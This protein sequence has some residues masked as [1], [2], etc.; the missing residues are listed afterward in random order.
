M[1]SIVKG[2]FKVGNWLVNPAENTLSNSLQTINIEPKAMA[3][4]CML[5]EAKGGVVSREDIM[6]K[7]WNERYVTDYALNNLISSLRKYLSAESSPESYIKT[8]PKKGYQIVANIVSLEEPKPALQTEH[9]SEYE[10]STPIPATPQD[11]RLTTKPHKRKYVVLAGLLLVI[12]TLGFM[13]THKQEPAQPPPTSIAVLPFEVFDKEAQLAFF[14]DGLAD[15]I[16]H[17]LNTVDGFSVISRRSSFAYKD[18]NMNAKD[19]A[20]ELGVTY[21]LEGSVREEKNAMR[22]TVQLVNAI[23]GTIGWSRVFT[24]SQENGF[25]IQ[26]EISTDIAQSMD[27]SFTEFEKSKLRYQPESSE[28]FLHVLRG[29]RLN[30]IGNIEAVVKAKD[31]FLMATLLDP[32]YD[33]A[34]VDLGVSYLLLQQQKA[35]KPQEASELFQEAINNALAINP[36][37]PEAHAAYGI[38]YYNKGKFDLSKASFEKALSQKPKLYLALVNYANLLRAN[39][40]PEKARELYLRAKK[41]APLSS[42]IQWGIGQTNQSLGKLDKA[43]QSYETCINTSPGNTNCLLGLAYSYRLNMQGSKADK[44]LKTIQ[45][46]VSPTDYYYKL[47]FAWHALQT[48][49]LETVVSIVEPLTD[50][51]GFG[52]P[53]QTITYAKIGLDQAESWLKRLA[54]ADDSQK[55]GLGYKANYA[56]AAYFSGNCEVAIMYYENML[57]HQANLASDADILA[58]G[59]TYISNLAYCYREQSLF[60]KADTKVAQ[61]GEIIS[62]LPSAQKSHPGFAFVK[63]QY[64]LLNGNTTQAQQEIELI[65]NSDWGLK[66]LLEKDPIVTRYRN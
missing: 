4:L 24:A 19:I 55:T 16:I 30:Q 64:A 63:A 7:I 46:L 18:T 15:E 40:Q 59:V 47:A 25:A 44:T 8:R 49:D 28:A 43:I 1:S 45:D 66:W 37:L 29:R 5:C 65:Q 39:Y 61:L 12:I 56:A 34:F 41:I 22:T 14:A 60:A 10:A 50:Q 13:L 33:M 35:L 2:R 52:I 27:A 26:F 38:F 48:N 6:L 32:N 17:Q 51:H 31:E 57:G 42:V 54:Q 3:L 62:S 20:K 11:S 21:I 53:I 36:N 58:N 23:S 9:K